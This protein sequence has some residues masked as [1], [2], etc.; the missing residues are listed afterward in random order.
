MRTGR[1][2]CTL[3]KRLFVI[4]GIIFAVLSGLWYA[5]FYER[6]ASGP[7]I[8]SEPVATGVPSV[9]PT[10][11]PKLYIAI[12]ICGKVN[13]P[14]VVYLE[15]GA[16]VKDAVDAADGFSE[17]ADTEWINLAS[18]L[19]DGERIYI[20][21]KEETA[22]MRPEDRIR[23]ADGNEKEEGATTAVVNINTADAARLTTLP[24]IGSS[25]A[26][27]IIAYRERVGRFEKKEDIKKVSGIGEALYSRIA[28]RIC[29]E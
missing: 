8:V 7:D 6:D 16:R 25:R 10:V 21:G 15:E 24:G 9:T 27:D 3:K 1:S 4:F 19:K 14:G 22:E 29:T 23:G 2:F 17:E 5:F 28:D 13:S 11:T 18:Y 20:P 12:H 26:N